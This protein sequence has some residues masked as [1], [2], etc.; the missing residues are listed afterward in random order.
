MIYTLTINPSIDYYMYL[1]EFFLGKTNR[2]TSEMTVFGGKGFNVSRMLNLMNQE[3]FAYGFVAGDSGRMFESL[4]RRSNLNYKLFKLNDGQTRINVK[5]HEHQET[6]INAAG[7][8]VTEDSINELMYTLSELKKGDVL[9]ISGRIARN[10]EDNLYKRILYAVGPDVLTYVDTSGRPLLFA[11]QSKPFL[12]KPNFK[13][14]QE[15]YT[16]KIQSDE[17]LI[18]AMRSLQLS[19]ARNVLVSLGKQGACLLKEDGHVYLARCKSKKVINTVGAGDC[20]LA[21]FITSYQLTKDP[22][23]SL[24]MAVAC[25]SAKAYS[26]DLPNKLQVKEAMMNTTIETII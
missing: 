9:V 18:S 19:G 11:L 20:L 7:P 2:A 15:V 13:E 24:L 1:D 22:R 17:Q 12:V 5:I 14:L 26:K 8:Y 21:G 3:N 10:N 6:E 25:G 23:K 16:Q 4:L